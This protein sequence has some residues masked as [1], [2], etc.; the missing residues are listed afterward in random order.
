MSKE[1]ERLMAKA[2]NGNEPGE[3]DTGP[4]TD[5][6]EVREVSGHFWYMPLRFLPGLH[7][8]SEYDDLITFMDM[9]QD[10]QRTGSSWTISGQDEGLGLKG[11]ACLFEDCHIL[12]FGEEQDAELVYF[13]S[14]LHRFA[15]ILKR[16]G[17]QQIIPEVADFLQLDLA[18]YLKF[19]NAEYLM[20]TYFKTWQAGAT[21]GWVLEM[22]NSQITTEWKPGLE[23]IYQY[24]GRLQRAYQILYLLFVAVTKDED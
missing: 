10:V 20:E 11:P 21:L 6:E 23:S 1:P 3:E 22:E 4:I 24:A 2:S 17:T 18:S 13:A 12:T 19:M 7:L 8:S 16:Y 5:P 14:F 9:V 15:G